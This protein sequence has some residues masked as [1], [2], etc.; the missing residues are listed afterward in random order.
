MTNWPHHFETVVAQSV[1]VG[2]Y[3]KSHHLLHV[4]RKWKRGM[5]GEIMSPTSAFGKWPHWSYSH[6]VP[7]LKALPPA[8]RRQASDPGAF[9]QTTAEWRCCDG[10]TE[11]CREN[12]GPDNR[13]RERKPSYH[14]T[15]GKVLSP[16]TWRILEPDFEWPW[17]DDNNKSSRRGR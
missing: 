6:L 12:L 13:P 10:E 4:D 2:T 17:K 11:C 8:R 9:N 14:Q 3:D 16:Y 15:L 1:V 5:G 7:L